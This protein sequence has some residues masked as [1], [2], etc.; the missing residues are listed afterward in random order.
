M[1]LLLCSRER[2][3]P[4]PGMGYTLGIRKDSARFRTEERRERLV[5]DH[6]RQT[7]LV[8]VSSTSCDEALTIVACSKPTPRPPSVFL[9]PSA[10]HVGACMIVYGG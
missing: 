1:E 2:L 3:V 10:Q 5:P 6:A 4:T 9:S 7:S 8:P